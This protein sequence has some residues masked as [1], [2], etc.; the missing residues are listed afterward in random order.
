MDEMDLVDLEVV[1]A[2]LEVLEGDVDDVVQDHSHNTDLHK[3][4]IYEL[5]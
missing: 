3:V 4:H 2:G 1:A 5:A